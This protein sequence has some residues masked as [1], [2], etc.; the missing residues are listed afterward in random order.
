MKAMEEVSTSKTDLKKSQDRL[1]HAQGEIKKK[2]AELKKTETAYNKDKVYHRLVNRED[3]VCS[4]H[5]FAHRAT[6]WLRICPRHF[7]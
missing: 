6:F 3:A 4:I 5:H 1:K 2:Q 7:R